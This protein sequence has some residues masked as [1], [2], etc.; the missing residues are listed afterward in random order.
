MSVS[1][2]SHLI[3]KNTPIK[4][5]PKHNAQPTERSLAP[6]D[7]QK[8]SRPSTMRM[9]S[10]NALPQIFASRNGKD[11][12]LETFRKPVE[13]S[14]KNGSV[15]PARSPALVDRTPVNPSPFLP[16]IASSGNF[17]TREPEYTDEKKSDLDLLYWPKDTLNAKQAASP[18]QGNI[19]KPVFTR[20]QE[21]R[22]S[23]GYMKKK[24]QMSENSSVVESVNK[25]LNFNNM[26]KVMYLDLLRNQSS[27]QYSRIVENSQNW[28]TKK[29]ERLKIIKRNPFSNHM[30][31]EEYQNTKFDALTGQMRSPQQQ[32]QQA[33][34]LFFSD[35]ERKNHI[36]KYNLAWYPSIEPIYK[37]IESLEG[38]STT[39]VDT[40]AFILGG[41][42]NSSS[43]KISFVY[44][45]KLDKFTP[46][47]DKG[48]PPHCILYHS[49][50]HMNGFIYVF[51]GDVGVG[52][53]NSKMTSSELYSLEVATGEWKK[54]KPLKS[55]DPRKH[56]AACEFGNFMLISGGISEEGLTPFKDFHAYSP[57]RIDSN[58]AR[59]QRVVQDI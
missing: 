19:N 25:R 37:E 41:F 11:H 3:L 33:M 12:P 2:R 58:L 44:D 8:S 34:N 54:L 40:K 56:H 29:E 59:D 30:D 27:H 45:A 1:E 49:A 32:L 43:R 31:D 13:D 24:H 15:S 4:L 53:K 5:H 18:S 38:S 36:K 14:V 22:R 48:N 7:G 10:S 42:S 6:E 51:G 35:N 20:F 17:Q 47:Q 57:G 55:I 21:I 28:G 16:T 39:L 52:T 23:E 50:I 9:P 26:Q 46:L